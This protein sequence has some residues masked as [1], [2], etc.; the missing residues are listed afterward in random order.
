MNSG[1]STQNLGRAINYNGRREADRDCDVAG[2]AAAH[3]KMRAQ[4]RVRIHSSRDLG[5]V[6][7]CMADRAHSYGVSQVGA[8]SPI[9]L[10]PGYEDIFIVGWHLVRT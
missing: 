7:V 5:G 1:T 2:S 4:T 6:G 8:I 9:C 10:R 3:A